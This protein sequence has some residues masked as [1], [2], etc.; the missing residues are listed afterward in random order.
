MK[1]NGG[2]GGGISGTMQMDRRFMFMKTSCSLGVV[3]PCLGAIYM[4]KTIVFKHYIL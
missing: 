2:G 4:F 3:C 1:L